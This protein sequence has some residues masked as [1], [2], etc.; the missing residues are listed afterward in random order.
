M[1]EIVKKSYRPYITLFAP[2]TKPWAVKRFLENLER[3]QMPWGETEIC[4]YLDTDNQSL[5]EYARAWLQR[6][7]PMVNG[8]K[9]YISLNP[10]PKDVNIPVQR[11][12]IVDM[13]E[14]SKQMIDGDFVFGIEDDTLVAPDAFEKL[15]KTINENTDI[16]YIEGVQVGRHAIKMV[17]V[18]KCDNLKNPSVQQTL[19]PPDERFLED[20][21][22][23][24][25]FY[26]QQITGGGFYCYLTLGYLYKQIKYHWHDECFGPDVCFVMDVIGEGYQ[27]W[28]DWS[29]KTIHMTEQR[30][31]E[32]DD[33]I[34]SI[35]WLKSE[36]DGWKLQPYMTK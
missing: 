33:K 32:V 12:R 10:E 8:C 23:K 36:R 30:D 22:S 20:Y 16:G 2:I 28:V 3:I 29:V 6:K 14:K 31:Y 1:L 9:I 5:I 25:N 27:A 13:K 35:R 19:V 17:G 21:P 26:L 18:W 34:I 15:H 11:N 24:E 4:F 7:A